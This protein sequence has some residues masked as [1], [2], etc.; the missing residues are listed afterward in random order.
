[1]KKG[2]VRKI[3]TETVW[4]DFRRELKAFIQSRVGDEETAD[5]VLQEV[6]VK[7][8]ANIDSLRDNSKL[9]SWAFQIARNALIDY[10]R[11]SRKNRYLIDEIQHA[12]LDPVETTN[13]ILHFCM[14]HFIRRLPE[15][16]RKAIIYTEY[17]GHSQLQLAEELGIN[18]SAAKSRVQRARLKI[19]TMMLEYSHIESKIGGIDIG[20]MAESCPVCSDGRPSLIFVR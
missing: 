15:I 12:G 16:Y 4:T 8:H 11:V 10:F 13:E 14:K 7:I 1:M 17:E 20:R 9:R 3:T 6:F 18:L 2:I 19:R 5:D